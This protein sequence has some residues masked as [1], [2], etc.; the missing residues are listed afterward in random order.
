LGFEIDLDIAE[1]PYVQSVALPT[2]PAI[3][4]DLALVLPG[5]LSAERVEETIRESAGALLERC[6]IFDEYRG[7]ELGGRSVAWRLVFRSPGRTLR[8]EDADAVVDRVV[9]EL[10]ERFDVVRR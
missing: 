4:R 9:V 3:E 8:E 6:Y 5:A 2:T 7:K 1:R 10:K